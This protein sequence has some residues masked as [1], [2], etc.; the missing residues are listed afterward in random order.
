M[1]KPNIRGI[2]NIWDIRDI[3]DIWGLSRA[4]ML[5]AGA[6][7]ITL[8]A[9]SVSFGVYSSARARHER[10]RARLAEIN[11]LRNELQPIKQRVAGLESRKSLTKVQGIV[12]AV[13][14]VFEPI[15]LKGKVKSVKPLGT[16]TASE[17]RAEVAIEG[18]NMNE[19]VNMLY[20][21]ENAPMLFI[22]RKTAIS[23]SF[24][25][26]ELLNVSLTLS[27]IT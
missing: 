16:K 7:V 13:E 18:V 2:R 21:I 4:E 23:T 9:A 1:K 19:M 8:I 10:A 20:S 15:G 25:N 11:A 3:R 22:I 24:E 6:L 17:E 12:D 26:P 27:L 14:K 5:M